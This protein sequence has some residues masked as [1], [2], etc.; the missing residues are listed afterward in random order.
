MKGVGSSDLERWNIDT[1]LASC[2]ISA[3]NLLP[4][5]IV[6]LSV[7]DGLADSE[8]MPVKHP[9]LEPDSS[10]LM[11]ERRHG[12]GSILICQALV[13]SKSKCDPVAT[14]IFKNL[15]SL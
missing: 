12:C 1:Y 7:C 15:V 2:Y 3:E 9:D 10:I 5:D 6:V 8:L 14:V 4:D 13:G 11:L